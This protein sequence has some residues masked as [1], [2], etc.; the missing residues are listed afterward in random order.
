MINMR[1]KLKSAIIAHATGEI[2]VHL[3]N[4]DVYLNNPVG[5]GEHSDILSAIQDQIDLIAKEQERLEVIETH[6]T[7]H[8]H[9]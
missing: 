9:E 8:N 7:N 1:E 3:A 2:Q 6:F 4:V 5:I